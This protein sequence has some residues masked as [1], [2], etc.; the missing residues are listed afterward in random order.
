MTQAAPTKPGWRELRSIARIQSMSFRRDLA[1]KWWMLV[2]FWLFPGVTFL[3][4]RDGEMVT[5]CIISDSYR[6]KIR[7]M[8]IAVHADYR[9]QGIGRFLLQSVLNERPCDAAVL[10]VQE[11]NKPAQ[12]LY[13]EMGF[14]R[15]GFNASYYG[16]GHAG[17]E[18]TLNRS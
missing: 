16:A 11:E 3:V 7:I 14:V 8:N 5:G 13:Q 6:G 18:M 15:S 2:V 1:Y 10:M 17:I 4:T 9:R 12:K